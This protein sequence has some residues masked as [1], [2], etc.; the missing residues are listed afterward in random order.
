MF[1]INFL[2]SPKLILHSPKWV[3]RLSIYGKKCKQKAQMSYLICALIFTGAKI[4]TL[5]NFCVRNLTKYKVLMLKMAR[6]FN[7]VHIAV[8]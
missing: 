5:E 3:N 2:F 1:I 7:S 6:I 8:K 4:D